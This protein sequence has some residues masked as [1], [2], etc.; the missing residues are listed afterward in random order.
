[1][2]NIIDFCQPNSSINAPDI[3]VYK[4]LQLKCLTRMLI[5]RTR[6]H[7]FSEPRTLTK[8]VGPSIDINYNV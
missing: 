1:M 5:P 4:A 6:N 2:Y 7:C 8:N 3:A